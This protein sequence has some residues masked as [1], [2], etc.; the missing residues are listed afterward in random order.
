MQNVYNL[1]NIKFVSQKM[2]GIAPHGTENNV[3]DQWFVFRLQNCNIFYV[4]LG[5]VL[6]TI[7]RVLKKVYEAIKKVYEAIFALCGR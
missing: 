7:Y 2:Y 3:I 6:D 4:N 5:P 1:F